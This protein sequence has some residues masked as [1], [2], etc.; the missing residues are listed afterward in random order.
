M[1]LNWKLGLWSLALFS[2]AAAR[3][4]EP[5][6]LEQSRGELLYSTYCLGC[7]TEQMHWRD[8]KMAKDWRSLISE[9]MHWQEFSKL[10]WTMY[11][12]EMVSRYLNATHYHYP[13]P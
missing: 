4:A 5:V 3:A 11:D 7:H 9:V 1:A 10:D 13:E 8:K 2:M 6:P 12:I